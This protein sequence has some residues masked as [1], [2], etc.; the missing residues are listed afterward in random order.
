MTC[1]EHPLPAAHAGRRLR[2]LEHAL[3]V[4]KRLLGALPFADIGHHRD[5]TPNPAAAVTLRDVRR[6]QLADPPGAVDEL[7]LEHHLLAIEGPLHVRSDGGPARG[8]EDVTKVSPLNHVGVEAKPT[9]IE[10]VDPEVPPLR[11]DERQAGGDGVHDERQPRLGGAER[12]VVVVSVVKRERLRAGGQLWHAA[13][14]ARRAGDPQPG[15]VRYSAV[16][17]ARFGVPLEI[18]LELFVASQSAKRPRFPRP[19]ADDVPSRSCR[20]LGRR[21][22]PGSQR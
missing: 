8:A 6:A 18:F 11:I 21:A 17:K 13:S 4:P 3:R 2:L 10:L 20:W 5:E 22:A 15:T 9:P 14:V 12:L 19:P 7:R 1:R 16:E